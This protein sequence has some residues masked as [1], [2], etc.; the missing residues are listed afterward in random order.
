MI[1]NTTKNLYIG[2]KNFNILSQLYL[3]KKVYIYKLKKKMIL[4]HFLHSLKP[5]HVFFLLY[6]VAK[7]FLTFLEFAN[8][9][10]YVILLICIPHVLTEC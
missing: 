8:I 5:R 7:I 4:V 1:V 6:F 3:N 10:V 9:S 2:V